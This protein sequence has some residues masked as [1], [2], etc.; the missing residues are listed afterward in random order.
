MAKKHKDS[1]VESRLT[2]ARRNVEI[3]KVQLDEDIDVVNEMSYTDAE[4]DK[5]LR[6]LPVVMFHQSQKV[7][8]AFIDWKDA[9]RK[10]KKEFALSMMEANT[11]KDKLGL[12]SEADRRAW[13][14]YRKNVEL[15][16]VEE[17][18]AEAQYR[19]AEFH[20]QAY[21]NLY[22]AVKKMTDKRMAEN[23]AQARAT[24]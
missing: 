22:M 8:L 2:S 19:M 9:K 18:Q 12:T 13:A 24:R 17:I 15:A 11:K 1:D 23:A 21:D 5:L 4:L 3:L 10:V 16:E 7:V 14:Q 6:K 20:F